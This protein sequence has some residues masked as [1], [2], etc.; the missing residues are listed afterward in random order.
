MKMNFIIRFEFLYHCKRVY[1]LLFFLMLVFQGVWYMIGVN[2]LFANNNIHLNAPAIIY[3]NLA[4]MG[5]IL[6][7]ITAI[8]SAGALARDL[9]TGAANVIYP[10]VI[11]EKKYFIGKYVGVMLANLAVVLGYPI[12]ILL[13]PFLGTAAPEQFGPVPVGQMLHGFFLLTVPN[14]IFLV[15][16]AVFLVVMTR[17]AAAAYLGILLVCILFLLSTSARKDSLYPL[18]VE[19]LDPF[20]YCSVESL[21]ETMGVRELNTAYL[22]VTPTLLLNRVIWGAVSL[23]LFAAAFMK[24]NFKTFAVR[25]VKKTEQEKNTTKPIS[26]TKIHALPSQSHGLTANLSKS[27]QLTW[28]NL[29]AM[30]VSPGILAIM[31][32][33]FLMFL[34][35]NFFWTSAYYLTAS[36]LPLTSVM[37]YIRIPMMLVIGILLLILSGELLFKDRTAGIWQIVDAMPTPSWVF[38]LSRFLAMAGIA[39]LLITLIFAAGVLSQWAMGF[40]DIEWGLYLRELYGSRF[41]WI[42]C[43]HLISLAFFCGVLFNSR[44]KG[45]IVSIAAFIF[46]AM[47][48]DFKLI[49]QLRFGFPFVPGVFGPEKYNYSEINGYGVLDAGLFWY[50]GAWTAL[51]GLFL[52]LSLLLWNRGGDRTIKERLHVLWRTL[53]TSG[54]R[55]LAATGFCCLLAFGYFQYGIQNNLVRLGGYQTDAQKEAEDA[56]YE[57][58]Y[59]VYRETPRPKITHLDLNLE[60]FPKT[61]EAN[62]TV[63]LILENRTAQAIDTLHVDWDKKLNV[64]ELVLEG[65]SCEKT[66]DDVRLRHA[67]HRFRPALK[68]GETMRLTIEA[69][70]A[71]K[72]F[73]QSDFQ[74]DLTYNG[75]VLGTD[76]LPFFGYDRSRELTNNKKRLRQGL[77]L[78][79]SRMDKADN[80]FSR[81][82]RFKSPQ[83]DRLEWNMVVGTD[84]DQRIVGPGEEIE[85]WRDRGRNYARFTSR[86]PGG[87]DFKI[88]SAR[89]AARE[90]DCRGVGCRLL[91]DPRHTYNLAV[92]QDA[93]EKAVPWL[94]ERLGP[95]PHSRALVVEKPF[96][97]DEFLSFANVAAISENRGWTAEIKEKED[98]QYIYLI[99]AEQLARQWILASL[100]V[101]DVQGAQL[102]TESIARY[103]AFRFMD[104]AWGPHQTGKWLDQAFD[105]Y[106]KGRG[107]EGI[108]E[109]PLLLVDDASYLSRD[110]G[111]LAL[112]ALARRVGPEDFDHWLALWVAQAAHEKEFLTSAAFYDA[113]KNFLPSDLR[114]FAHDWLEK[115][116]QYGLSLTDVKAG[117]RLVDLTIQAAKQAHD[118]GNNARSTSFSTSLEVGL[119]DGSG[120]LKEIKEI[121]LQS[122]EHVYGVDC[123]F[124]PAAVI[125]DPHHWY[126]IENRR[127]CS[128]EL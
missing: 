107:E 48:V 24:F 15:T 57:K 91:H 19:L 4:V 119:V 114:P 49:E 32:T 98:G 31:A 1:T 62:Y 52:T 111:G 35:Y 86:R 90:F 44:L 104:A 37:T 65:R 67:I 88:I 41:G 34:G 43:L 47:S 116:I 126:L 68:P 117:P 123:S 13:F 96:Y 2:D 66:Q 93:M 85:T 89:L 60:L 21:T 8:I 72:G 61:R 69:R 42:T 78:L 106:E 112:Y 121:M 55:A 16:F 118:R 18:A 46:I 73:H 95:S 51:A 20:G 81:A 64:E 26:R 80:A 110:K 94:A 97:D 101:A 59:A 128:R 40:T 76:F 58:R 17:R 33:L 28:D 5:I 30:L 84:A 127:S 23:L 12:G 122:G 22:P 100:K 124:V 27:L 25:F 56:A 50:A 105:D 115:R 99:V 108:E 29:K 36:H 87:M 14:L 120:E 125:L 103:Y 45:H 53:R 3:R 7:A 109:K 75:T 11:H 74:S 102:L 113:L 6:F 63:R 71:Y 39:F 38:V 9:E 10:A 92:F 77:A 79:D 54:G 70:L 83:S 82:N